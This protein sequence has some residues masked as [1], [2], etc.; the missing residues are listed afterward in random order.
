MMHPPCLRLLMTVLTLALASLCLG[1]AQA[2][3]PLTE[4]AAYRQLLPLA[5]RGDVKAQTQ[6]GLMRKNGDDVTQDLDLARRWL[7]RAAVKNHPPA[8]YELGLLLLCLRC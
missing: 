8:Q 4:S 2:Q 7:G 5:N 6:L 3:T 1:A